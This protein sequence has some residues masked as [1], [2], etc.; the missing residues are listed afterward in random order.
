MHQVLGLDGELLDG[1]L[2]S[3]ARRPDAEVAASCRLAAAAASPVN[4]DAPLPSPSAD[5][6]V[7]IQLLQ[8]LINRYEAHNKQ[9]WA[10][11]VYTLPA[12][13]DADDGDEVAA[14]LQDELYP[15][16]L[17]AETQGVLWKA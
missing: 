3:M 1:P 4:P 14:G 6:G 7:H 17:P 12:G 11:P 2:V 9:P 10:L 16:L 15:L 13:G 5:E 8:R